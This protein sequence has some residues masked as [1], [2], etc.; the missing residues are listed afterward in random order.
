MKGDTNIGE[1]AN[2]STFEVVVV[3]LVHCD[4]QVGGS[5]KL[6]EPSGGTSA[7]AASS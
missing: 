2:S 4:F 6:H 5:L 7:D 3:K 1:T